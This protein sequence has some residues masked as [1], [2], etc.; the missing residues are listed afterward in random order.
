MT[1]VS[2]VSKVSKSKVSKVSQVSEIS[3]RPTHSAYL[4]DGEDRVGLHSVEEVDGL[5]KVVGLEEGHCEA[6]ADAEANQVYDQTPHDAVA[7]SRLGLGL[8][9]GLELG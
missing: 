7:W 2:E 6:A 9:F 4:R 1:R 8:G 5:V 3:I